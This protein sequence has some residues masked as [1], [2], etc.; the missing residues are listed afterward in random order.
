MI[1]ILLA[2]YNASQYLTQQINSIFS[3]ST[4]N[5]WH[6]LIRDDNSQDS[7]LNIINEHQ[8]NISDKVCLINNE[9]K[10]LGSVSNFSCLIQNS[11][12]N[13]ILF[14]DQDDIWLP[15]KIEITF[16]KML[17]MEQKYG[18]QTPILI[19][20][21][22]QVVDRN[23]NLIN[24]SFQKYQNLDPHP[25]K[26]LPR[27]LVQNFVTGC[28]MMI[29]KPLKEL[30]TTIP[31]EAIMH[32]WWIALIAATM[33]KIAYIKEPTVLYRQH[34]NNTIGANS[35]GIKYILSKAQNVDKIKN[36]IQRTIIQAKKFREI[37]QDKLSQEDIKI[38]DTYID[39][40]SKNWLL[41]KYLMLNNGYYQAGKLKN[42]GFFV[43]I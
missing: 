24:P 11:T 36:T 42:L 33:G 28:T 43:F 8:H 16:K 29:N 19:H 15:N 9:S 30:I 5:D 18:K 13:Y 35:W 22:L 27:L 6:L 20:T 41:R 1:D 7:T 2:T 14:C 37:Y 3:Q 31:P 23:L 38:I 17:E 32:D 34:Q 25:K 26:L 12:S 39:M 21:D 40:P 4:I 10:N